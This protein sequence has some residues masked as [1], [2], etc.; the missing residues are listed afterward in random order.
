MP[1]I[2]EHLRKAMAEGKFDDLPGKGKPL[3]IEDTNPHADPDWELAF[4]MLKEAGYTLPWIETLRDIE[5]ELNLARADLQCAWD[6]YQAALSDSQPTPEAAINWERSQLAFKDKLASLNKRI[7]EVNLQVPN[8]RFQHLVLN[9]DR[10]VE[11]IT[12]L[13]E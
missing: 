2:E 3:K 6:R 11:R 13:I 7:R 4:R 8:A 1:N 10:E 5:A 12:C 9:Y